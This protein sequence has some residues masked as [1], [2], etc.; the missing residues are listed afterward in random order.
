M[1]LLESLLDAIVRLEGD[2]LVMHVGEKPYVVTASSSMNAYRGPLAWGQVELSSRVLTP[3]AVLNMVGQILPQDQRHALEEVGAVEHAIDSP[4]GVADR[5]TVVAARGGEDIWL[6][7]RRHPV[8]G[9]RGG[10]ASESATPG[11]AVSSLP[12]PPGAAVQLQVDPPAGQGAADHSSASWSDRHAVP[13]AAGTS[14]VDIDAAAAAG[15]REATTIVEGAPVLDEVTYSGR[16]RIGDALI[17]LQPGK[18]DAADA[19]D[20]ALELV[21]PEAQH[22]PTEEDVD[23]LLAAT[24]GALLSA[25]MRSEPA[26]LEDIEFDRAP[27]AV[28]SERFEALSDDVDQVQE[29]EFDDESVDLTAALD[30]MPAAAWSPPQVDAPTRGEDEEAGPDVHEERPSSAFPRPIES[31]TLGAGV[32]RRPDEVVAARP[33][34]ITSFAG[35]AFTVGESDAP[36]EE[37]AVGRSERVP[38]VAAPPVMTTLNQAQSAQDEIQTSEAERPEPVADLERAHSIPPETPVEN[39]VPVSAAAA[40]PPAAAVARIAAAS[41]AG[42]PASVVTPIARGIARPDRAAGAERVDDESVIRILRDAVERGAAT[43]YVVAQSK[44]MLRVDGEISALDDYHVLADADIERLVSALQPHGAGSSTELAPEWIS[45]VPQV[46]RVRSVTFRDHRG[47]GI[48]FRLIPPRSISAEHLNLSPEIRELATLPDGFVLVTG[49]RGSGK[50]TLLNSFVDLINRSRADHVITIE[51]AIGFVHDSKRSFVSQREVGDDGAAAAAA[52]GSA[53]REDPDVLVI[54]DL[55]SGDAVKAALEAAESGRLVVASIT[56]PSSAA[57]LEA[58]VNLLPAAERAAARVSLSAVLRGIVGQVLLRRSSGGH[59]AARELLLNT[60][61][62]SASIQQGEPSGL[63]AALEEAS[64]R[65]LRLND[66]L[67]ALV[68]DGTVHGAEAYRRT[69]DRP[70]LIS[71]LAR[72]GIDTSFAERLA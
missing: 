67:A 36:I 39:P 51:T 24:A 69:P 52:L 19:V 22:S 49:A 37:A 62:A 55:K 34:E 58:L 26:E 17:P 12:G 33:E 13:L 38:N 72:E 54:D 43:V 10:V 68:K 21:E 30:A 16:E 40:P 32:A 53:L 20:E 48:I 70:G 1:T 60:P 3:D 5:F 7:V 59:V 15:S 18:P 66:S 14:P 6:E 61:G 35:A 9:D 42:H 71:T 8:N 56:A 27:H 47:P 64:H 23:S 28:E 65:G 4:A 46:G 63:A 57:A 11:A 50:S 2:A 44:P 29:M 31:A 25:N 41:P 45:E